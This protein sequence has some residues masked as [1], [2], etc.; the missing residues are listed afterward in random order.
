MQTQPH[1]FPLSLDKSSRHQPH[2]SVN[3]PASITLR[4]PQINLHR[5][6]KGREP[7]TSHPHSPDPRLPRQYPPGDTPR[8][9]PILNV[10]L[11]PQPLERTLGPAEERADHAEVLGGREGG[12]AHVGEAVAQL[13]A[14][15]Q[16]GE[17]GCAD[18]GGG[19]VEGG[20]RVVA[21]LGVGRL[22]GFLREGGAAG[23]RDLLRT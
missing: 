23:E 8:G 20:G 11:R 13:G 21:H 15:G 18:C 1:D 4:H 22:V 9:D 2:R 10:I 6:A 19:G 7:R 14:P 17:R 3:P 5:R 12:S 16:V